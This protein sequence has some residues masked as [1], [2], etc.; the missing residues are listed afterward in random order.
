MGN[1]SVLVSHSNHILD[2]KQDEWA[3]EFPEEKRRGRKG[4]R[5]SFFIVSPPTQ[6]GFTG[7]LPQHPVLNPLSPGPLQQLTGGMSPS[8]TRVW[9]LCHTEMKSQV[10]LSIVVFPRNTEH[11][12]WKACSQVF[13]HVLGPRSYFL[14]FFRT[15]FPAL[16]HLSASHCR[17]RSCPLN[18]NLGGEWTVWPPSLGQKFCLFLKLSGIEVLQKPRI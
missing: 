9:S 10:T 4:E 16:P 12:T 3:W 18:V 6:R 5:R 14:I 15:A 17:W 1:V 7:C 13:L 2:G 8:L 11:Q